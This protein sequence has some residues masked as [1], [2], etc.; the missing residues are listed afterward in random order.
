[1][2]EIFVCLYAVYRLM[3]VRA[4]LICN[5]YWTLRLKVTI[6]LAC[7]IFCNANKLACSLLD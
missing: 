3:M 7:F 4:F 2:E 6:R 5:V 1:M